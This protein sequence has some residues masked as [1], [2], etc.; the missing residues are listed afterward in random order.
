MGE[1]GTNGLSK[2]GRTRNWNF[3]VFVDSAPDN[4]E[5]L[6]DDLCVPWCRSPLHDKDVNPTGELKKPHYHCV[7]CFDSTKAFSQVSA[8]L[9]EIMGKGYIMPIPC[10]SLKGSVRYFFHLDNPEKAQYASSDARFH[11]LSYEDCV[12]PTSSEKQAIIREMCRWCVEHDIIELSDLVDYALEN[13]KDWFYLLTTQCTLFMTNY[14]R[15]RRHKFS[16]PLI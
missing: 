16:Q 7:L 8:I 10:Q 5:S 15:S 14:I 9:R 12:T 4:W 13:E 11:G 1:C 2:D 3:V 6:I